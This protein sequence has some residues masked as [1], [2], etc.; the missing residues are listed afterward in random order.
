MNGWFG[1]CCSKFKFFSVKFDFPGRF[2]WIRSQKS[3]LIFESCLQ[4]L[5]L[6][7]FLDF[8]TQKRLVEL[9]DSFWQILFRLNICMVLTFSSYFYHSC[10]KFFII[11]CVTHGCDLCRY[12]LWPWKHSINLAFDFIKLRWKTKNML[13][14]NSTWFCL[15]LNLHVVSNFFEFHAHWVVETLFRLYLSWKFWWFNNSQWWGVS[16]IIL[17]VFWN[18]FLIFWFWRWRFTKFSLLLLI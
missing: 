2:N 12:L 15:L 16:I 17:W 11:Q 14:L 8:I 9:L 18:I 13:V 3:R 7:R 1:W 10:L 4:I 5:S 6:T